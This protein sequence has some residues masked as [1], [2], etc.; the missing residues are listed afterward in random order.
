MEAMSCGTPCVG[1]ATGGIPEMIDHQENG[2]VAGYKN[3]QDLAHGINWVLSES[4]YC[5]L[6]D[7]ARKKV[8]DCYSEEIVAKQ[9]IQLYKNC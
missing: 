6:S 1:F 8:F 9:Y 4:D 5:K 7:N 3:T 2:Y